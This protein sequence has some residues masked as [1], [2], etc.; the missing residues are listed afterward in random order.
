MWELAYQ[1]VAY[2]IYFDVFPFQCRWRK[3]LNQRKQYS[4]NLAVGIFLF[5]FRKLFTAD[6]STLKIL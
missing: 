3:I 4:F 1:A 6:S 5:L 2:I